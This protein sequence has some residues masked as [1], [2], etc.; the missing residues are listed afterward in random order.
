MFQI[1]FT[2]IPMD[3]MFKLDIHLLEYEIDKLHNDTFPII[4][5]NAGSTAYGSIDDIES[6]DNVLNT[7]T[8]KFPGH[9]HIDASFGGMVIPFNNGNT[10]KPTNWFNLTHVKTMALD[11]HKMAQM[12]YPSGVFMC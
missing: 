10:V 3:N 12:P 7:Y 8:S 11:L 5:C 1:P 9:I 4:I 2:M 6:I